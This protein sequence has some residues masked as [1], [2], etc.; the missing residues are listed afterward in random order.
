[1]IGD[2][3][4]FEEA[5]LEIKK[6]PPD[7]VLVDIQLEG[8]KDGIDL[9]LE[10]DKRK[11]PFLYLTSQTDPDT[12]ERVKNTNPLGYIVKPFTE[13]GLRSNIDVAWHNYLQLREEFLVFNSEGQTYKV[14]QEDILY[15]KAFDN[16]C[17]VATVDH[18]Y[19]VPK[20]LKFTSETLNPKYFVKTHRSCLVNIRKVSAILTK[21][22]VV[23]NEKLPLS[24]S[25][26]EHLKQL[27]NS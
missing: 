10:L 23:N 8:D 11:I 21:K 12:I 26:R 19:L 13:A 4:S 18:T 27:L 3:E 20:T 16:Y 2:S 1:M 9:A 14:N 5:L 22:V 15:L 25:H 17:Y 24:A 7:L 6:T